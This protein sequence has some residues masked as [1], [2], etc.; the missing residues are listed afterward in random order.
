M[1]ILYG[2]MNIVMIPNNKF[3]IFFHFFFIIVLLSLLIGFDI[4]Q[5]VQAVLKDS[6]I[7]LDEIDAKYSNK[8]EYLLQLHAWF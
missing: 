8:P 5:S 4:D 7:N 2:F 1:K 6:L 3:K